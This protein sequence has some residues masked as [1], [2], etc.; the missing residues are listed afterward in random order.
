MADLPQVVDYG[1][2]EI[3][4]AILSQLDVMSLIP[5]KKF[6]PLYISLIY[7]VSFNKVL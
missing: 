6:T 3:F 7:G 4:I 2:G 1:H 5:F